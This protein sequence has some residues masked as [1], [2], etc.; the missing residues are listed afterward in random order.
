MGKNDGNNNGICFLDRYGHEY[1]FFEEEE[2]NTTGEQREH[3]EIY[4]EKQDLF[5]EN[6][7][8]LQE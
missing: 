3:Q 8:E 4:A 7:D 2:Q 5:E 6:D 1:N